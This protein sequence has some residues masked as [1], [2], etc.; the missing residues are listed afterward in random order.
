MDKI[1]II[2]PCYNESESLFTY[3]KETTKILLKI[4]IKYEIIFIDDGQKDNTLKI[5]KDLTRKNQN[6]KYLSLSRNFGKE[7]ALIAG[8]NISSGNIISFMDADLQDPPYL[9]SKMYELIKNNNY[10]VI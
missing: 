9:L 10:D 3:Y 6:I 1:S 2:V 8:L 7:A 5:I 4:K